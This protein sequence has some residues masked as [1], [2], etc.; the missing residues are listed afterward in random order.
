MTFRGSSDSSRSRSRFDSP[1]RVRQGGSHVLYRHPDGRTTTLPSHPGSD[2][3]R[4]LVR[5]ILARDRTHRRAVPRKPRV[6]LRNCIHG[7][8]QLPPADPQPVSVAHRSASSAL[9]TPT[10]PLNYYIL[11]RSD[12]YGSLPFRQHKTLLR[13]TEDIMKT[14]RSV[15]VVRRQTEG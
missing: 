15:R 8:R 4:P 1:A 12:K 5:E 6:T 7:K 10:A 2:L 13:N 9:G 14:R 3:A 11:I